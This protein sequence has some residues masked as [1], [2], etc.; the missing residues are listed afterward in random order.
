MINRSP[1]FRNDFEVL[2]LLYRVRVLSVPAPYLGETYTCQMVNH[3]AMICLFCL[4]R[5]SLGH[6]S[7]FVCLRF[8]SG[9]SS[10]RFVTAI[11]YVLYSKHSCDV[12]L[13]YRV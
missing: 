13:V 5:C 7:S 10:K 9:I 3:V 4:L 6:V 1:I 11:L 12:G 2:E 8:L